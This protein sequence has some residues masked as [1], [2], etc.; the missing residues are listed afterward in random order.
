MDKIGKLLK[1]LLPKE[2]ERLEEVLT[3]LISGKVSS[4][5]IK[6][7]KG[8][9]EIYRVRVGSLRIIFQKQHKDIRI[10]EVSR[11]DENTYE[12]Y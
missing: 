12:K 5:N 4:L 1:K 2:R 8:A 6:K 11:R 3:M 7:L 9:N 10:L